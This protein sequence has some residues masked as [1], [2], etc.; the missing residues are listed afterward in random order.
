MNIKKPEWLIEAEKG[1]ER[2]IETGKYDSW[3][4]EQIKNMKNKKITFSDNHE[5]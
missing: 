2:D 3:L 4:L 1:L 5:N